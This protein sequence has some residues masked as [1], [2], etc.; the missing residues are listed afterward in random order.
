MEIDS[1]RTLEKIASD[2]PIEGCAAIRGKP[3]FLTPLIVAGGPNAPD[4]TAQKRQPRTIVEVA[5]L[6][7]RIT[8]YGMHSRESKFVFNDYTGVVGSGNQIW[9]RQRHGGESDI[10]WIHEK[11]RRR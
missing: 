10:R 2:K 9:V 1:C 11:R 4:A 7:S 6:T 5:Y 3:N 8:R